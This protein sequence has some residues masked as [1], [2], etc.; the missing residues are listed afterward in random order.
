[1]TDLLCII[2]LSLCVPSF[3]SYYRYCTSQNT[4]HLITLCIM[5][6]CNVLHLIT[7]LYQLLVCNVCIHHVGVVDMHLFYYTSISILMHHIG[8]SKALDHTSVSSGDL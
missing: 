3:C 6:V 7:L 8:I 5:Y 2:S 4:L 1:M